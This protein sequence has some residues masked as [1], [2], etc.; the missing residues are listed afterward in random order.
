MSYIKAQLLQYWLSKKKGAKSQ[1]NFFRYDYNNS[2]I[3]S[4][5]T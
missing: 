3:S 2:R 4:N 5:I 1:N